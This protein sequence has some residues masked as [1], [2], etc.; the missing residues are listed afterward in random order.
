M[1]E[2]I[3]RGEIESGGCCIEPDSPKW[4][5]KDCEHEWGREMGV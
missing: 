4:H 3:D 1:M 2:A 5:C